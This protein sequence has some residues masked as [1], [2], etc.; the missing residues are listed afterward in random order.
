MSEVISATSFDQRF[1]SQNIFENDMSTFWMTTGLYPQELVIDLKAPHNLNE[2]KLKSMRV[3]NIKIEACTDNS[4]SEFFEVGKKEM[5]NNSD[6]MQTE[7]ISLTG[8]NGIILLKII[9]QEGHDDFAS[10]HYADLI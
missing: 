3:K 8:A 1:S 10:I 6:S 4:G 2:L 9:I 5:D 7:K